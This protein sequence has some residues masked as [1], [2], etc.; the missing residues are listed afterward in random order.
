[1]I[2]TMKMDGKLMKIFDVTLVHE[3]NHVLDSS[4]PKN[5]EPRLN[6]GLGVLLDLSNLFHPIQ[7]MVVISQNIRD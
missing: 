6:Q 4:V 2:F 3:H 1:M 5:L 7:L